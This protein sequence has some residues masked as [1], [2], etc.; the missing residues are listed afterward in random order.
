MTGTNTYDGT[1]I[2]E[3]VLQIGNGGTS[4]TLGTG[5]VVIN[6]GTRSNGAVVFNRS[7]NVAV[8]NTFSGDGR[9]AQSGT[10]TLTLSGDLSEFS[11]TVEVHSGTLAF[12]KAGSSLG[13]ALVTAGGTLNVD[14]LTSAGSFTYSGGTLTGTDGHTV[15][16]GSSNIDTTVDIAT[17]DAIEKFFETTNGSKVVLQ[18]NGV[19]NMGSTAISTTL[20]DR[21]AFNGGRVQATG[22]WIIT[23]AVTNVT[24]SLAVDGYIWL[25]TP[26][27]AAEIN[28]SDGMTLSSTA[29]GD[30]AGATAQS[31]VK[32]GTGTMSVTTLQ[33]GGAIGVQAG[34]FEFNADNGSASR[35][36]TVS[37][38]GTLK[39]TLGSG[40]LD[41]NVSVSGDGVWHIHKTSGNVD[42]LANTGD[43][44]GTIKLTGNHRFQL[45]NYNADF[46]G[47]TFDVSEGAQ[48]WIRESGNVNVNLK[49]S[50]TSNTYND[51]RGALRFDSENA[52]DT[53]MTVITGTVEL[54]GDARISTIVGDNPAQGMISGVISGAHLLEKSESHT[55][56]S[57]PLNA[58][59]IL[60]GENTYSGGTEI[61]TGTLQ[62]GFGAAEGTTLYD[63]TYDGTSGSLGTGAVSVAG[64]AALR[65]CRTDEYTVANA[66]TVSSGGLFEIASGTMV[67]ASGF[68][69]DGA[70]TIASGAKFS[71]EN[72]SLTNTSSIEIQNG[73]T[74]AT[75][76]NKSWAITGEGTWE[77]DLGTS[78]DVTVSNLNLSG[79]D[80][81]FHLVQGRT[82]NTRPDVFGNATVQISNGASLM[83][84]DATNDALARGNYA[85]DFILSGTG[86]HE[87]RG[88]LRFHT[89]V[90]VDGDNTSMGAITGNVQIVGETRIA[91]RI[92]DSPA[93]GL[94]AGV[95]SGD[96]DSILDKNDQD[97]IK[98]VLI[99]TGDNTYAG[100]T[101][102]STGT[103]QLGYTGKINDIEYDGT[104]GTLGTGNLSV[105]ADGT[106][107]YNRSNDYIFGADIM[108]A[109]T[110]NVASGTFGIG[111]GITNTGTVEVAEGAKLAIGTDTQA[112]ALDLDGTNTLN[113]GL[114]FDIFSNTEHDFIDLLGSNT[115]FGEDAFFEFV[116]HEPDD[117]TDALITVAT[118]VDWS[119]ALNVQIEGALGWSAY[120]SNGNLILRSA[121]AVPE[122]SSWF[123]MGLASA[124]VF[125]AGRRHV[126]RRA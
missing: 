44:A 102:V 121:A 70:M 114:S 57:N 87:Q 9:L 72:A 1:T 17:V 89:G 63:V 122:P 16:V 107:L 54:T 33:S 46:S 99:L 50:G 55:I 103:L 27:G 83:L 62:V 64:V 77:V 101:R 5:A 67:A 92:G 34:T 115:T 108:N 21:F 37:K 4:G 85:N 119:G 93:T 47:V 24:G 18:S 86:H 81:V 90:V 116:F 98:G 19:V 25:N 30:Y 52:S 15:S 12:G 66:F 13:G 117:L 8:T 36:F 61:S 71:A 97:N 69:L 123:L 126:R 40:A 35:V 109:G 42:S 124:L 59:L 78:R 20:L 22:D 84:Y 6:T 95:I 105:L 75:T 79:F 39:M 118:G 48:F 32:S 23:E 73:G 110:I 29:F 45:L 60:T 43:F 104:T 51:H 91:A 88:A 65:Y 38:N 74:L 58:K 113:G 94:I 53:K 31:F 3:G 56:T 11:G 7:D 26:A 80:G 68:S 82:F 112:V 14:N 120:L 49:L 125:F 76:W 106:L 96:T 41:A 100:Q 28:V 10:G 111:K 2:E